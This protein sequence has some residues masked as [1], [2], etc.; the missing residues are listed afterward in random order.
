M[1]NVKFVLVTGGA[2]ENLHF[3][4]TGFQNAQGGLDDEFHAHGGGEVKDEF[5]VCRQ[6]RQFPASGNLGMNEAK[7]RMGFHRRQIFQTAGGKIVDDDH[8]FAILE[9]AL[10]QMRTDK[11]R[12][13]GDENVLSTFHLRAAVTASASFCRNCGVW[14]FSASR[15]FER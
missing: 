2:E 10:N 9:Q 7:S 3:A 5:R 14:I 12:A 11:P 6:L 8:R 15:V 1:K 4:E 13:A